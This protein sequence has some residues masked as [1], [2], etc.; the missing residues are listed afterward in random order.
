VFN[1]Q[2]SGLLQRFQNMKK[3]I[4]ASF[5]R[6]GT[7]FLINNMSTNFAGIDDGW[8][9]VVHGNKNNRWVQDITRKNLRKKIREQLMDVYYQD[10]LSSCIK[11]HYQMYFFERHMD[12]ILENYDIL[13]IVRDPRDTMVACFNYYNRTNFEHFLK[14]PVFSKFL[15]APLWE[16]GTEVRPFSYSYV[17]PRD[18]VD[19][20]DK[21]VLSWMHYKGQGVVFVRFADLKNRL[22]QTLKYIESQTSQRLKPE[23]KA[24]LLEDKRYRPDFM[25]ASIKR[26]EVGIW[27]EYFS[28]DDLEFLERGLSEQTKQFFDLF[29]TQPNSHALRSSPQT[30]A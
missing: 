13:Y 11:T 8:V 22:E 1:Q 10:P 3:I 6:S 24:V 29:E 30:Y 9:D 16:V 14:E 21:H 12:E 17:K 2:V 19:K 26:G 18:V 23:I 27:R 28:K 5:P 7:H 15:R 25:E 20:W 4:V